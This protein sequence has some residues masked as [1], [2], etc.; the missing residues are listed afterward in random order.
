ML[1]HVVTNKR[2]ALLNVVSK[3]TTEKLLLLKIEEEV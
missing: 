2:S 3:K 1:W